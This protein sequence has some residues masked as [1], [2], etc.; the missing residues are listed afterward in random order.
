MPK[1]FDVAALINNLTN[2]MRTTVL[3]GDGTVDETA[4]V[5]FDVGGA[6]IRLNFRNNGVCHSVIV[7]GATTYAHHKV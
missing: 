7:A 3:K 4:I 2:G 1:Q 6:T 5:I